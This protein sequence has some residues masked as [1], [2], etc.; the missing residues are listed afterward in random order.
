MFSSYGQDMAAPELLL[1]LFL[2]EE[3]AVL[4]DSSWIHIY[5]HDHFRS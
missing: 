5:I 2:F 4:S 1:L 3:I